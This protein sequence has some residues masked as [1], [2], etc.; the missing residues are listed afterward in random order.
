MERTSGFLP[1][2]ARTT[3]AISFRLK[4]GYSAL[5][6]TTRRLTAGGSRFRLADGAPKRDSMPS[7]AYL[8]MPTTLRFLLFFWHQG[9]RERAGVK[10]MSSA[11][12][13]LVKL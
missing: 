5:R 9:K 12:G 6:S 13:P 8:R 3:L 7:S 10:S 2:A 1:K 4:W 11:Y